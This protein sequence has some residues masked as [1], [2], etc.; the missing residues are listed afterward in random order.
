MK[1]KTVTIGGG[2]GQPVLLSALR[3]ISDIDITAIVTTMDDGG[4]TGR[5]CQQ[6]DSLPVGDIM[7]C[8]IALSDDYDFLKE[9][10]LKIISYLLEIV[11]LLPQQLQLRKLFI[12]SF[13]SKLNKILKVG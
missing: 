9:I 3:R 13:K 2:S 11:K 1:K 4:S 7:K 8:I 5:L 12:H 10:F 6:Y